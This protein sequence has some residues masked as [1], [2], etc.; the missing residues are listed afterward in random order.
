MKIFYMKYFCHEM[1]LRLSLFV[2]SNCSHP[3]K[4]MKCDKPAVTI[5]RTKDPFCRYVL[6]YS[7][8]AGCTG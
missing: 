8:L 1:K 6:V 4:C 5:A 3:Q 2:C 7:E